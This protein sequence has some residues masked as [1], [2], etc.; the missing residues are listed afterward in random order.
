MSLRH[1]FQAIKSVFFPRW[2]RANLWRISTR[3]RRSVH[4]Y[5]DRIRRVIEVVVVPSD[6]DDRDLLLIH[7]ICHAVTSGSHGKSWQAR[8][9]RAAER[10][11]RF[12]RDRLAKLLREEIAAYQEAGDWRME[13]YL[14]VER[15]LETQPDLTLAQVKR[16]IATECGLLYWEV[17]TK[18]RRLERVFFQ[19]RRD[20]QDARD[21][22]AEANRA[23]A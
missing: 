15:W 14:M 19:S 17:A 20:A 3:S 8:M 4:G 13:A 5:C 21:R 12:G 1:E 2:D 22:R 23:T 6:P 16:A 7:E 10:A 9:G 18:L 11:D